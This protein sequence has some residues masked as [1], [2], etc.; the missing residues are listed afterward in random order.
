[1]TVGRTVPARTLP[2]AKGPSGTTRGTGDYVSELLD[3]VR[4][5]IAQELR[6]PI[7][8]INAEQTIAEL[9]DLDS[10]RLLRVITAIEGQLNVGIDDDLIYNSRTVGELAQLF[11][12]QSADNPPE[13]AALAGLEDA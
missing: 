1:M 8:S 7:N 9:P 2:R 6:V 5:A 4:A 3:V 10:S 13:P 12:D 11:A